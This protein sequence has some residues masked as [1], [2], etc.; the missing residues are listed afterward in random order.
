M[1][2]FPAKA[3][4]AT[5]GTLILAVPTGLPDADLEVLV[6]FEPSDPSRALAQWPSGFFEKYFGAL[7]GEGFERPPQ[8]EPEVR[9][10]V[11]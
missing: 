6:V 2:T 5:D 1:F 9:E 11:D 3:R 7:A 10:S 4:T 8:G